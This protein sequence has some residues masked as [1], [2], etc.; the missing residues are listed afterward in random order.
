MS[1]A[2]LMKLNC[3]VRFELLFGA[4]GREVCMWNAESTDHLRLNW[5][6]CFVDIIQCLG[7][8]PT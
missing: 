6:P 5:L 1:I 7:M 2:A 3:K 8:V 4:S